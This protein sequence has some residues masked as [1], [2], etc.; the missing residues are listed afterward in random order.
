M[1]F[2]LNSINKSI[3]FTCLEEIKLDLF[4]FLYYLIN[5]IFFIRRGLSKKYFEEAN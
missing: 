2:S 5:I 3:E 4:Y 1:V